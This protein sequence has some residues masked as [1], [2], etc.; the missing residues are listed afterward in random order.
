MNLRRI[1]ILFA[2]EVRASAGNFLMIFAVIVPVMFSLLINLVFGDLFSGK[3]LMGFYDPYGSQFTQMLM[4][5]SHLK[6]S[7]YDSLDKMI[8]D[9]EQGRIETGYV[10]PPDFDRILKEGTR[11]DFLVYTWGE[12]PLK[13]R[14][15]ADATIANIVAQVAGLEQNISVEVQTLGGVDQSSLADRLLPLLIIM[16]MML[17]GVLVPAL[18]MIGEKQSRTLQALNVTPARLSEV[19]TAKILLGSMLGTCTGLVTLFL[20]K[21]FGSHPLLLVFVLLL[22]ALTASLL[23]TLLGA[24]MKDMN[25]LLAALKAGGLLL[26]APGILDLI[27]KAPGWIAHLF[28]TYYIFNP[29]IQ[30]TEHSANLGDI[31]GDLLVLLAMAGVLIFA[32]ALVIEHQQKRLALL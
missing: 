6:T 28:P 17:C 14:L 24:L 29:V 3:P 12:T 15:I 30:V 9:V 8:A 2:R 22:G 32:L 25:T 10:V 16:T 23:G 5:Q 1:G 4:A 13:S 31:L 11:T 21:A 27:P 18:S 7:S 20:N 19:F 26:I